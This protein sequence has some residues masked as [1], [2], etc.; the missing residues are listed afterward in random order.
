M[1]ERE[2]EDLIEKMAVFEKAFDK[3][4]LVDPSKNIFLD[5][6]DNKVTDAGINCFE[7]WGKESVCDNCIAM[8]AYR[9]DDIFVKIE[10]Y[11][12]DIYIVAA[13]PVQLKDRVVVVELLKKATNNIIFGPE[14]KKLKEDIY[15]LIDNLNNVARKDTLTG[16]YNRRYINERIPVDIKDEELS[17]QSISVIMADLDLFKSINDSYGHLIG[18]CVLKSFADILQKGLRRENDWVARYGGEEFLICMPGAGLQLSMETAEQMRKALEETVMEF[19]GFHFKI[20]ASFGVFS[21]VP[22]SA[23]TMDDIIKNADKMLYEAKHNGRN[24]V[25]G[26]SA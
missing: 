16:I 18:D 26:Y 1:Y 24:R 23:T 19:G 3:S 15:S 9:E 17:D 13:V 5:L 21:T 2:I 14:P 25:E 6:K 12:E 22:N 8:R 11:K 20:T 4:R 10:Y 7:F